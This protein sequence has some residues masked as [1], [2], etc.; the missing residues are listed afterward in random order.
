LDSA[1]RILQ[2]L[3]GGRP[4][5]ELDITRLLWQKTMRQPRDQRD[6]RPVEQ[7]L[8]KAESSLSSLK[9]Q[10]KSSAALALLRA[11]ICTSQGDLEK[12]RRVLQSAAVEDPRN[13]TLFVGLARLAQ[14][15]KGKEKEALAILDRAEKALGPGLEIQLAR[16]A[17]WDQQGGEEAKAEV[18]KLAG[19][20]EQVSAPGLRVYLRPLAQ[21]EANLGLFQPARRHLAQ[22]V[23]LQP[24][25]RNAVFELFELALQSG[26]RTEA[27]G[28]IDRLYALENP[29]SQRSTQDRRAKGTY[30]RFAE[31]LDLINQEVSRLQAAEPQGANSQ[32]A[33]MARSVQLERAREL[34]AEI[35]ALRPGWWGGP[36]LSAKIADLSSSIPAA[37]AGYK[38]ALE[39]GDNR[40]Q[41]LQRLINLL[42]QLD[43]NDEI[44]Q[45]ITALRDPEG[46]PLELK[47]QTAISAMRKHDFARGLV[48]AG[49]LFGTSNQY[50]DHLSLARFYAVAGEMARAADQY[51]RAVELGPGAP[52][53][54]TSYVSCL[55]QTKQL[56]L[57]K[58]VVEDARKALPA[59]RSALPLAQCYTWIGNFKQAETEMQRALAEKSPSPAALRFAAD[60]EL[61]R[62]RIAETEK[63]L[64]TL[65]G[66]ASGAGPEDL[67]WANRTRAK[68]LVRKGRQADLDA[69]RGL[70]TKNLE[71]NPKSPEDNQVLA[72]ILATQPKTRGQAINILEPLDREKRLGPSEQFLLAQ[73]YYSERDEKKYEDEMLKILVAGKSTSPLFLGHYTAYLI[74]SKQLD[75]AR[76]WLVEL[77]SSAPE[78]VATLELE[79]ML[80]KARNP[81]KTTLPEVR[82]LL[83]ERMRNY[84]DLIGPVASLLGSYGFPAEAEAAYKEF[85]VRD[86]GKPERELALASFLAT[87]QGRLGEALEHLSHA[88]KTCPLEQVAYAALALY[89]APSVTESQR[90]QVEAWVSEA[91]RRRPDLTVLANKLAALWIRQG[92]FDEAE[93]V[94]RQVLTGDSDDSEAL[95]NLAWLLAL[96]DQSKAE[97]A[98]ELINRAI[99]QQGPTASLVDTKAVALIR[100]GRS[101][102]AI[103][104]LKVAAAT[105]SRNASV[106]LHLAWALQNEGKPD[107]AR[108][109]FQKALELGW[110]PERSDPLERLFMEKLRQ[111]LG[112]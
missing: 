24:E 39:L 68:L 54:W 31:A 15:Q 58:A 98:V 13:P 75:Q 105:N 62:G 52:E 82:D 96:R 23:S 100:G 20:L 34:A 53:T 9:K 44:D 73:L 107:E 26:E 37:I 72:S 1:L 85:M 3:V 95:N 90:K 11:E 81:A 109:A 45:V 6:W 61:A 103:E 67:A 101:R 93:G 5:I 83:V 104:I 78:S 57:A 76:S 38:R 30:W 56:D 108:K 99:D 63:Y 32:V 17:Y 89:D 22:L 59:D 66:P 28:L 18:A 19:A 94:Y 50:V 16:L 64:S 36:L 33:S 86:P 46:A 27:A 91:S 10:S 41:D 88:R 49:E 112:L 69:A 25:D 110:K 42:A 8:A 51:R 7:E 79:A 84:P 71:E 40:P 102:D 14:R 47:L 12:A 21:T 87:Q 92:R 74:R 111:E 4:E 106:P 70:I 65:T 80:L 97:E 48:L 35:E 2:S 43:R 77:K 55:V 29:G 60:F